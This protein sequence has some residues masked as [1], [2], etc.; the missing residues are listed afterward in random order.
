MKAIELLEDVITS[1]TQVTGLSEFILLGDLNSRVRELSECIDT[2][3]NVIDLEEYNE[4]FNSPVK[5]S[6]IYSDTIINTCD[7]NLI[8]LF[9]LYS[10]CILNGR[11]VDDKTL[12]HFTYT[13][14]VSCSFIAYCLCSGN[15]IQCVKNLNVGQRCESKHFPII[16]SLVIPTLQT[17]IPLRSL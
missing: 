2:V 11:V 14:T 12:G 3:E 13:A 10:L 1:I 16:V 5:K 9:K 15:L 17:E 8:E 7:R 4:I 6:R